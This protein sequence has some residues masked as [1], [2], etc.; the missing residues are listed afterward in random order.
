M[1]VLIVGL[2]SIGKK[3]VAALLEIQPDIK[4]WAL[5]SSPNASR[6]SHVENI[7]NLAEVEFCDF[8][9]AIIS[10][11]TSEHKKTIQQLIEYNIPL[12]IE[13]P[14]FSSLDIQDVIVAINQQYIFT[15]IACNLRFLDCIRYVKEK[16]SSSNNRRINEVNVYCGSYLPEWRPNTDYRKSYSAIPELGGGVHIDLIHELDYIYWLFGNPKK[17]IRNYRT[18]SSL[19]IKAYDY[20]NYLLD[21]DGFSANI[22]LNYFRRDPKRSLEIVFENETWYIDLLK[23]QVTCRNQIIYSTK[24]H[25]T[26]TYKVQMQYFIN[27]IQNKETSMNT[28]NDAFNVLKICLD[29]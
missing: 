29:K 22:V 8:D 28:I 5:R 11:P 27:C 20:A 3:H 12:F 1:K 24:Q 17:I 18:Q 4:I 23:N 19:A 26:D 9:F 2:G 15:Y 21:F 7:Y 16:L 10:N 6:I 25:I 13:K 14:L